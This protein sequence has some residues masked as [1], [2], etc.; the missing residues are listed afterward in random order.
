GGVAALDDGVVARGGVKRRPA[1]VGGELL[2][3]AEDL[4]PAGPA[5][6]DAFGGGV[7]VFTGARRLGAGL[8]QNVVFFRAQALAP[9]VVGDRLEVGLRGVVAH[10]TVLCVEGKPRSR[11]SSATTLSDRPIFPRHSR[12][13]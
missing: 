3:R 5:R 7:L 12:S 6:V 4:R 9:F 11:D 8:T 1:A 10:E 2:G 13:R